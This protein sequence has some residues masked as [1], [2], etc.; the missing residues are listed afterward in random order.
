LM[1]VNC[2]SK[3]KTYLQH[4]WLEEMQEGGDMPHWLQVHAAHVG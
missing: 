4:L 1:I 2:V 3:F